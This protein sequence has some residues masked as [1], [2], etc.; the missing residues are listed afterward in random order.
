MS[1]AMTGEPLS[2][3]RTSFVG[4][5]RDVAAVSALLRD[6][7]IS[8]VTLTG[9]G[10]I[11]KT[12]LALR[13]A[14]EVRD[15]FPSGVTVV[16]L[17]AIQ[18]PALLLPTIIQAFD[19]RTGGDL[20]DFRRLEGAL[21]GKRHLLVIDSFEH[22][23]GEAPLI[24]AMLASVPSLT[25]LVTS[26]AALR[27]TNERE[28]PL[29]PLSLARRREG[30]TADEVARSGA[31]ELFV[32]RAKAVR[33]DFRLTD[34]NAGTIAEIVARLDGLPLAIELAAVRSKVLAPKA[35]LARLSHRL[36]ILTGGARD[37]PERLRTMRDA[38]AWSYDLLDADEQTLFRRLAVFDGDFSLE[39]AES[40]VGGDEGDGPSS[41]HL[42]P[43]LR[44]LSSVLDGI[45]SLVDKSLLVH[46][47][48]GEGE[49]RYRMLETIREFALDELTA[50]GEEI[51]V[52]LRLA[53]W[54]Q[55]FVEQARPFLYGT[56]EQP[57]WLQRLALERDSIRGVMTWA[58]ANRR[59]EIGTLLAG[60]LWGYWFSTDNVRE[61]GDWL[62]LA[63]ARLN[64]Q[65]T[66][67]R[68]RVLCG[69]GFLS[70]VRLH[71]AHARNLLHQLL[72]LAT[73]EQ[74]DLY[75]GWGQFGLGIIAQD[76][77]EPEKA[78]F[79]FEAS[80]DAFRRLGDQPALV[81]TATQN[82]GLVVSRQGD[83]ERGAALI[84]EALTVFRQLRFDLG[85][86]I[87]SRF[88]GQ[89][90]R[91]MGDDRRAVPLLLDSLRVQ[92]R[93]TQ[94][95]HIANALEALAG[96]A[97]NHGQET[98]ATTLYGAIELF[99]EQAS[100][101]LEPALQHEHDRT[102]ERLR[103][104]LGEAEFNEAWTHGRE[105]PVEQAIADAAGVNPG[106]IATPS[107]PEPTGSGAMGLTAR[108]L[109]VLRLLADG[110]STAEIA[111]GLFISP[112]TVSTHV[113]SILGKLGVPTRSAAVALALRTG[114]V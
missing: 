11:G 111:E 93:V 20:T 104:T 47:L 27:L 70:V 18:N 80:R 83:F 102:V 58:F 97:A 100:A 108:E 10:G 52:R 41:L 94:Q 82:L 114:L 99:R 43:A 74:R 72:E 25:V 31:V 78:Q 53:T 96:I 76:L 56:A 105:L 44:V 2:G 16:G 3:W 15:A 38:I 48:N 7:A 101:P 88:L 40:I 95:W 63:L 36:T 84:E 103:A 22:L 45:A 60:S 17:S 110:R 8:L 30:A 66:E 113:A 19:L 35:L 51:A 50:C 29:P 89:V 55:A 106:G 85:I 26:R 54:A 107:V 65:P 9:P 87:S 13:V 81:A 112:R 46:E 98:L 42:V 32:Q 79:H 67:T 59:D 33:P 23:T 77:A 69:A 62:E 86:A 21:G 1:G 64:G 6:P 57:S 4:R 12:R 14:D 90:M 34:E 28:Y 24:S 49:S 75:L 5:E 68:L 73:A 109:E 71:F 91:A 37:M 39:V 61:G 92:R